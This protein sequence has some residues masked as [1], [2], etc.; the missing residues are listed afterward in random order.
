MMDVRQTK[1]GLIRRGDLPPGVTTFLDRF[2]KQR[3]AYRCKGKHIGYFSGGPNSATFAE[4]YAALSGG[5]PPK[6][7]SKKAGSDIVYFVM[8]GDAVKIGIASNLQERLKA[9]QTCQPYEVRLLVAVPGGRAL[10]RQYHDRYKRHS[11]RGEW[12][13]ADREIVSE[14]M[15]LAL[16]PEAII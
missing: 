11:L 4:E 2:G 5:N 14:A 10:E 13:S 12:F 3:W 6:R 7:V 8:C 15:R 16:L 9:I 1:Y